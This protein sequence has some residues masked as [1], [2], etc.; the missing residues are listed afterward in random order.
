MFSPSPA[1]H[2][3][4]HRETAHLFADAHATAFVDYTATTAT[5]VDGDHGRV[6]LRR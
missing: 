5:T 6:E 2:P 4:L 1:N 3:E